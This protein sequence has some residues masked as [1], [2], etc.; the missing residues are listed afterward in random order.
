[1][2]RTLRLGALAT[3]VFFVSA[4]PVLSTP[5]GNP[6]DTACA[7]ALDGRTGAIVVLDVESGKILGAANRELLA[8]RLATPGSSVK[9]F[10]LQL[11][12]ERGALDPQASIACRRQLTIGGKRLDCSHPPEANSFNAAEALA[13]SCNSYF[14]QAAV[15]LQPGELER[16]YRELGF[17]R[18]TNLLNG[19]AEGLVVEAHTLAERQLLALGAAG[20][21][22]TP[23]ELAVAYRRL[24]QELQGPSQASAVVLRGL[25]DSVAIGLGQAAALHSVAVAGKTG[26]ASDDGNASTHAWFAGF[27]PAKKPQ[28]VIVVFLEQGRGSTDAAQ[29]AG[30]VLRAWAER[31]R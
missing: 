18:A 1:M 29:V 27:A 9:P 30:A 10:V 20:V 2:I 14:A 12:L 25:T 11:L 16:R 17:T 5:R 28:I 4:R 13:F 6:L 21:S 26:T 31:Q 15:R 8:R 7:R 22:I 3:L 24:A 19:D 23:L